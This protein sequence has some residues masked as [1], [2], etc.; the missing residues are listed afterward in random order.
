MTPRRED[1]LLQW[2]WALY[3]DGHADRRNLALHVASVPFFL[4]GSCAVVLAPLLSAWLALAGLGAMVGAVAV[5]G[6]GHRLEAIKPVPFRSPFDA[7]ARL[8]VEQWITFPRFVLRG[9]LA[10]AWRAAPR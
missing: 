1:G 9:D 7:V 10:R 4:L 2:Q 3:R 5:Q 8:F 6:R